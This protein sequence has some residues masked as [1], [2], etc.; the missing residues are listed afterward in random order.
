MA[1]QIVPARRSLSATHSFLTG[2]FQDEGRWYAMVICDGTRYVSPGYATLD[3]AEDT[4]RRFLGALTDSCERLAVG[5]PLGPLERA[6]C[7]GLDTLAAA[8]ARGVHDV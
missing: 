6:V 8:V 1:E 2:T 3:E 7:A 4:V 5:E